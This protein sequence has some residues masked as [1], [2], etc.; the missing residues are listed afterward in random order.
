MYVANN[1]TSLW[2][3][4]AVCNGGNWFGAS[5]STLEFQ[6][7]QRVL[8]VMVVVATYDLR[9]TFLFYFLET[10]I[11][12]CLFNVLCIDCICKVEYKMQSL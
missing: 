7:T 2:T 5:G 9:V 1:A 11:G 6:L 8:G 3:G 4:V 12:Q 10:C